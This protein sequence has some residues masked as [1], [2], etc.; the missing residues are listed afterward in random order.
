MNKLISKYIPFISFIVFLPSVFLAPVV[1]TFVLSPAALLVYFR[2]SDF[3]KSPL[4]GVIYIIQPLLFCAIMYFI[5][6]LIS[7][8]T[9]LM[10][11]KS[12]NIISLI[13][14]FLAIGVSFFPIYGFGGGKS[15]Y[16][17]CEQMKCF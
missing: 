3:I 11:N 9:I 17:A 2:Y 6:H 14:V 13:L 12:R 5:A 10:Q 8:R 7:K 16:L 15:L 4:L 1:G